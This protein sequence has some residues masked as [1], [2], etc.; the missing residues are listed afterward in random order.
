MTDS[1]SAS[2]DAFYLPL[3]TAGDGAERFAPTDWSRSVWST[4]MQHGSPPAA[5][6]VRAIE[7]GHPRAGARLSRVTVELLGPVP[8]TECRVR[9]RVL[10]PGR[11]IELIRAD[12]DAEFGAGGEIRTVATATAWRMAT[13][14]T[15]AAVRAT[16]APFDFDAPAVESGFGYF[17]SIGAT[18]FL[19][20]VDWRWVS[21]PDGRVP[22]RAVTRL[23]SCVVKGEE[24][25]AL[26][27]MFGVVDASN[28][29]GATLDPAHW[30]FLNTEMTVH[31][32]RVPRGEH[33]GIEAE[34]STGPDGIGMCAA[35]IH[36]A[37]GPVA[38]TAQ[39]VLVRPRT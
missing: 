7:R 27:R 19:D 2:A 6:L 12:L 18:T 4:D 24:P 20:A 29:I 8:M 22:G 26:E 15:A 25:S 37:D 38:R 5:L 33:L 9:T 35:V 32:H 39:S 10:R 11:N 21:T 34:A 28:G 16:D 31:I 3:G 17:G 1:E 14:D 36:D 13:E 23:K 30:T